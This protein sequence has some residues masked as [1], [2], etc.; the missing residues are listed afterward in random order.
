MRLTLLLAVL[1]VG[2]TLLPK[3]GNTFSGVFTLRYFF[4]V[5]LF[6]GETMFFELS[7]RNGRTISDGIDCYLTVLSY[8]SQILDRLVQ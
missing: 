2:C 8:R 4:Y 5:S 1:E 6:H 3:C 7:S